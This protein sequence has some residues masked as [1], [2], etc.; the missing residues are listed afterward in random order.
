MAAR[1]D[2]SAS[3]LA[4][5]VI[6]TLLRLPMIL[7]FR[8]RRETVAL[9]MAWVIGPIAGYTDRVKANLARA[10]PELDHA[11][12]RRL[13][14]SVP[15]NSGRM[16]VESTSVEPLRSRVA[17]A[18][19]VG[20]GVAALDAAHAAGQPIVAVSGHFGNF[21]A[22]RCALAARGH[23]IGALYRPNDDP[24]LDAHYR[25]MLAGIAEP[26]FPRGRRG[27]AQMLRFLRAGNTVAILF[28]QHVRDGAPLTFFGLPA[29]TTLSPAEMALKYGAL[30]IPLYGIRK[31]ER[32]EIVCEAPI[33]HS[34]PATMMQA[35]ND[36]LEAQVRAHP[37][38]WLW[39]HRRW[40]L[41]DQPATAHD[42][43]SD[44]GS[45]AAAR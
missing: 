13:S 29:A 37:E 36:S 32:F 26:I 9:L 16:I 22:P 15:A 30:L 12:I 27:L 45:S 21:D 35:L 33:P 44:Q 5:A 7:P 3:P 25:A 42:T 34:D 1:D 4:R 20:P 14:R 19:M 18:G 38:Q 28:D 24:V 8:L 40:K 6:L 23:Q 2:S 31:G 43:P 41:A 10:M 11:E 17:A 39:I